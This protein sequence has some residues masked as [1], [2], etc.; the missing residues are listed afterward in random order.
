MN[1]Q[2]TV[3]LLR[4][5]NAGIKMGISS[6]NDT[7][8]HIKN[9]KF[10]DALV[11]GRRE[12]EKLESETQALLQK[13]H[14]PDKGPSPFVK[15]MAKMKTDMRF[16]LKEQDTVAADLMTDGCHMGIKSLSRYLN[17][18]PNAEEGVRDLTGRL[19]AVEEKMVRDIRPYL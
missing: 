16:F 18:Y 8:P 4:E 17:Q 7:I 2:E 15:A 13:Y 10:A 9:T 3:R 19:I 14:D 6:L 11:E 5:C 12:H 1:K